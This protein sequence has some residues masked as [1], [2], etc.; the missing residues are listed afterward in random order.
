MISRLV[1]PRFPSVATYLKATERAGEA[2]DECFTKASVIRD[3][4]HRGNLDLSPGELPIQVAELVWDPP[5]PS[6]QVHTPLAM[7]VLLALRDGCCASIAEF[8]RLNYD[9]AVQ[10]YRRPAYRFMMY[11]VSPERVLRTASSRWAAFHAGSSLRVVDMADGA[12]TL[13]LSFPVS[14][15][16]EV[17]LRGF[18][19]SLRAAAEAAGAQRVRAEVSRITP[20]GAVYRFLWD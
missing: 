19:G 7:A 3:T 17:V 14:L 13:A 4:V 16:D 2:L 1:S 12:A 11:T 18:V 8:E 6:V 15:Y 10:M 5:P 20:V 9:A